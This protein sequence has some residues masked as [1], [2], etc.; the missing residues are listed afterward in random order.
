MTINWIGWMLS[1]I[2]F[3]LLFATGAILLNPIRLLLTG[4]RTEGTV[5]GMKTNSGMSDTAGPDSLQSPM[6]EFVTSTGERIRVSGRSY[7]TVPSAHL[8]D[9]IT[10]AYSLSNPK[11]AQ[12][13]LLKEFP[14]GPVGFMLG[15]IVFI[16]LIWISCI[17]VMNAPEY[18]DPFHLLTAAITRFHLNPV[19]FPLMFLL[20]VV[21]PYC[22]VATYVLSK[23]AIDLRTNGIKVVGY[24]IGYQG[25]STRMNNGTVANGVFPMIS[26]KDASG[27][28]HTIRR[29]LAKQ[30]SRLKTGDMVEI[31]YPARYPGQG[32]VNTWDEF[33]PVPLFFGLMTLAFLFLLRLTLR[34][35]VHL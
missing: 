28:S 23:Q 9:K 12:F 19:L 35:L 11:N 20:S 29:S 13:L 3:L 10:V 25:K 16:L 26:Y 17:M 14:L 8:G 15:F 6:V 2:V 32:V 34:G 24:V 18:G 22:G 27:T 33:Y 30:L 21:I 4:Q 5:V 31:I 7:S 1:A